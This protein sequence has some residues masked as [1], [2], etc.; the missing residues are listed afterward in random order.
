VSAE[1]LKQGF[2][3][4]SGFGLGVGAHVVNGIV[5]QLD[6]EGTTLLDD[7]V[8]LR[9]FPCAISDPEERQRKWAAYREDMLSHAGIAI[10]LF[11]N[12][13][14]GGRCVVA[15]GMIQEFEIAAQKGMA[16]IPVGCTGSG[17]AILHRRV[18]ADVGGYISSR[19]G[20]KK[21][22]ADLAKPGSVADVIA[23]IVHLTAKLK[24]DA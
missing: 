11:G 6:A 5:E 21:L 14:A 7:R 17:A 16:V 12:K 1:L 15:D 10:F 3:I 23:R 13:N 19:R 22:V 24:R 9:P 18:L 8:V 20:Y 2:G 4:V